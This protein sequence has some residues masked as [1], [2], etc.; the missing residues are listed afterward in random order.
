MR[1]VQNTVPASTFTRTVHTVH[2]DLADLLR[3]YD[4]TDEVV[5]MVETPSGRAKRV[6]IGGNF[7]APSRDEEW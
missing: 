6:V 1:N 3:Q 2:V 4:V 5:L 7:L